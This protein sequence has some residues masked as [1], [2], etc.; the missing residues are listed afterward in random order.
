MSSSPSTDGPVGNGEIQFETEED[1][2]GT[3]RRLFVGYILAAP[4]FAVAVQSGLDLANPRDA[5]ASADGAAAR[6]VPAAGMRAAGENV[7][8]VPSV[9]IPTDYYDLSDLLTDSCR[10]TNPLL[11]LEIGTDGIARFDLPR[12]EVG[13]GITTSIGMIIADELDMPLDKVKVTLRDADPTLLYNQLTGGSNT[14]HS[15][16]ETL[17]SLAATAR[18]QL[19]EAAAKEWGVSVKDV[20][21]REGVAYGPGGRSL[22]YGRLSAI[23]VSS[24]TKKVD[25]TLKTADQFN[26]IG[27]RVTRV[28]ARDAVTGRKKYAMDLQVK[29]ALPTMVCHGPT[30]QSK[31]EKLNNASEIKKMPGVTHVG[32]ISTGVAVRARTFGQ[33]IDAVRAMKISW[34]AG[35][36]DDMNNKKVTQALREVELP[37]PPAAPGTEM[38]EHE[39]MF[40][41]RSGSPMETNNAIADVREDSAE[42]WSSLKNPIIAKQRFGEFLGLDASKVTVHCTTGGGSF[43]RHLFHDAAQEAVESSKLFGKPVRLMWHRTEDSRHG[44]VHSAAVS[45]VRALY[46]KSSVLGFDFRHTAVATDYTHGLGEIYSG[47]LTATDYPGAP[48]SGNLTVAQGIYELTTNLPYNFGPNSSFLNEAFEFDTFNTSSVRNVYSPDTTTAREL[49][50]DELAK[51]FGM[52]RLEFRRKFIRDDRMLKVLEEVAKRGKWGRTMAK[53]TAQGIAIHNEY[54]ARVVCLMEIDC[55]PQTVKRKI[56]DAYTGPR[57]TKVTIGADSG[58]IINQSGFEAMLMGGAIDGIAQALTAGLHFQNGLPAEGS[59]DD[60]RYTRQWN[61]P[62]EVD[63][64]AIASDVEMP[65]GAGELGC[66]VSQA[67]AACAYAK[68]VG[69]M[70]TEFPINFNEPLGFTVKSRIPAY[71]PS[72]TN[73]LRFAR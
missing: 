8:P 32:V 5:S 23:A 66:G 46:N 52:D 58:T 31:P 13:Q 12:A 33:C 27:K 47:S 17:R 41:F 38:I 29:D 71:P 57:V 60:Y 2:A 11:T 42:V 54:K 21:T 36:V 19:S 65:G 14:I 10:P 50:V 6:A 3:S 55:R 18:A 44:R 24:V 69:K 67:A 16:W 37:I 35:T 51:K 40:N 43:G 70:P 63:A 34:S 59:W 62:F 9:S 68:A 72:P 39:F 48:V 20:T 26:L 1:N 53:G 22:D 45:R 4:V 73:G 61:T 15:L 7:N 25:Y 30:I 49:M 28:D 64:F 56:R